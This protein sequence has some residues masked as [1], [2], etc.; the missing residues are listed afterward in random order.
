MNFLRI[1][2]LIVS[3]GSFGINTDI[4]ETN[5]INQLILLA[6]LFVVGGDALG[7]SLAERQEEIIKNVEDSEKRLSEATSRLEE[8]KLQ[9]T[10]SNIMIHSIRRQAKVTK[11]NLLNS[12]YEQTKLELA[13]RFNSTTTILSLK[14]REVLS[15]L[16][17]HIAQL[18]I[19]RVIRKL[20]KEEK[21]LPDYYRTRLDCYLEKSFATIGSPPSTTEIVR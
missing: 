6:G 8:A 20:K 7:A 21:D 15:D 10:Q 19:V 5:L 18:V 17:I 9:L 4:F 16:R 3:S 12:D 1:P 13:K 2:L 14:E 11:I